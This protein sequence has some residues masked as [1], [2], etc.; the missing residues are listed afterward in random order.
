MN[1]IIFTIII[2]ISSFNRGIFGLQKESAHFIYYFEPVDSIVIDTIVSRLEGS[3]DRITSDLQL[4][5]N[6]KTGVHVYPTLQE[7]HNAIDW[8]NAPD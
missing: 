3:Y 6:E 1:K 7:F 2:I 4:L 8:P 5:L